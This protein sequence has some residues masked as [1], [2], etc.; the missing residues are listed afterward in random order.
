MR[1][2]RLGTLGVAAV[3]LDLLV[4]TS[5]LSALVAAGF[6]WAMVAAGAAARVA[7]IALAWRLPYVGRGTGGW[8]EGVGGT[9]AAAAAAIALTVAVGA[10]LAGDG[11]T[12]ALATLAALVVAVV[13][14]TIAL[15]RWS[16]RR[17][18]G[19][20]G[21]V[22]GAAAELGETLALTAALAVAAVASGA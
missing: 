21:D 5:V 22:F 19:V 1:D 7:P 2:P 4:K 15:G 6:P 20:T 8:T 14:V 18:E 9:T 17:L 16:R 10:S 12:S 11:A 3:V 13:A